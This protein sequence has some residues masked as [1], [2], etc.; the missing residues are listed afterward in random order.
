MVAMTNTEM[1]DHTT[2]I[3]RIATADGTMATDAMTATAKA[4]A[5]LVVATAKREG[6]AFEALLKEM[7]H[8]VALFAM[9]MDAR[10]QA[11]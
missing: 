2:R 9:D 8:S 4:L 3:L 1:A 6:V 10:S 11:S 7:L 5:V